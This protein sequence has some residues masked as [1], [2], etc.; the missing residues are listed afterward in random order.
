MIKGK[1]AKWLCK[2]HIDLNGTE[3]LFLVYTGLLS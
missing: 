1:R 3:S 2:D